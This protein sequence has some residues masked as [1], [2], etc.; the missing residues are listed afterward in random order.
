MR[1]V[2]RSAHSEMEP[3]VIVIILGPDSGL[4]QRTLRNVLADRDPAGQST[5]Y[6]DGNASG[7]RAVINDISSIGFFRGGRV[8]VVENLIARLGKQGARD[9]GSPPDWAA[10]YAAVPEANTLVLL[11]PSLHELPSLAKK[12]LPKTARLE[13]SQPPRGT[14]LVDW[15]VSTAERFQSS[16]D[17]ATAQELAIALFPQGWAMAPKNPLYDRPPD[18]EMLENEIAKLALAAYPGAIT[19]ATIR[20]MT[21][22]EEDDKIFAFLDAAAAGNVEAAVQEMHKL[23]AVGE[24]PA[25][26]LAQLSQNIEIGTPVSA[27]GR[28]SAADIG[29][30]IDFKNTGRISSIQRG[31]QGMSPR[32]AQTR[33]RIATEADRKMKTGQ[34]KDPIDALYDTILRIAHMRELARNR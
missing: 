10:L 18:M 21:P 19:S 12:P 22:R 20:Q 31:L 17:R 23:I 33:S 6:L 14:Q 34:L 7:I 2:N 3:S 29:A 26:L 15:I 28:A 5:S 27:A 13:I 11:D 8:V 9:A 4:A 1:T 32:V 30:A 24:D 16:V 25:K